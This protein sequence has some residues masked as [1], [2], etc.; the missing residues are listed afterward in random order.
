[1]AGVVSTSRNASPVRAWEARRE[2][3]L[4]LY[5]HPRGSTRPAGAANAGEGAA[6]AG[7]A[8]S[9]AARGGRRGSEAVGGRLVSR[10]R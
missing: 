4:A 10:R 7:E 8:V 2:Q 5:L 6:P 9:P 1:M 3:V